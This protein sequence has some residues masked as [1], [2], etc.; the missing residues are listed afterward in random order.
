MF[1]NVSNYF[2]FVVGDVNALLLVHSK[3]LLSQHR[4]ARWHLQ[5]NKTTLEQ[6]GDFLTHRVRKQSCHSSSHTSWYRSAGENNP[7]GLFLRCL[8][9]HIHL[10]LLTFTGLPRSSEIIWALLWN[11]IQ[12]R[13]HRDH[14]G[15][16][17]QPRKKKKHSQIHTFIVTRK[18]NSCH[19]VNHKTVHY[20]YRGLVILSMYFDYT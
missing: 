18:T 7:A 9:H 17:D 14:S 10:D 5:R 15:W 3:R 16:N 11:L 2:L 12:S 13:I 20:N 6:H 19:I 4:P 8:W 1:G